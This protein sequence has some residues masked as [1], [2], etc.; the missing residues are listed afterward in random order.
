VVVMFSLF[1]HLSH[2]LQDLNLAV[3][4]FNLIQ[5]CVD[6]PLDLCQVKLP[7]KST[8]KSSQVKSSQQSYIPQYY[9]NN[10][11]R[12]HDKK[13]MRRHCALCFCAVFVLSLHPQA[14]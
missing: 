10:S 13:I 12:E 7:L 4:A 9:K 3:Q 8:V 14:A 2:V 11:M 5:R 1:L 6:P